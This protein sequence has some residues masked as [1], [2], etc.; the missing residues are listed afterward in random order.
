[1]NHSSVL[2]MVKEFLQSYVGDRDIEPDEEI[3]TSGLVNSLFAMQLV[4]FLEKAF[5]IKVEN[6]DLG[7]ENF[8]SL[9][10]IADFVLQK[11]PN[12]P[13]K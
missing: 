1:M 13:A 11:Q 2:E 4:L 5:S 10:T 12:F 9:N 3:F 7:L 6:E 8:K